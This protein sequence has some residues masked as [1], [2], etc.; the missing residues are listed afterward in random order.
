MSIFHVFG[1]CEKRILESFT[2]PGQDGKRGG[3][4]F[5]RDWKDFGCFRREVRVIKLWSE[6]KVTKKVIFF[7]YLVILLWMY[8]IVVRGKSVF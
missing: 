1:V 5:A 6:E 8:A 2:L 3:V 7:F 4:I